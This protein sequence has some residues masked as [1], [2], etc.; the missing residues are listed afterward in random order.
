MNDGTGPDEDLPEASAAGALDVATDDKG[1]PLPVG[2]D[3][4]AKEQPYDRTGWAPKVG[5]PTEKSTE[6]ES[7]L[8]HA[9]WMEGRLSDTLYGG[10]SHSLVCQLPDMC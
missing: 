1:K 9:T 2:V 10:K 7:L 3:P 8:D 6:A 4:G 5:W